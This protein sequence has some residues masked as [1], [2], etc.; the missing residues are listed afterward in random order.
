M[1]GASRPKHWLASLAK[2]FG[3]R[4]PT[5]RE[6]ENAWG[7][8]PQFKCGLRPQM[9][10]ASLVRVKCI[11]AVRAVGTPPPLG[12]GCRLGRHLAFIPPPQMHSANTIQ[13]IQNRLMDR[14]RKKQRP[15][16]SV[17][18]VSLGLTGQSMSPRLLAGCAPLPASTREGTL[19]LQIGGASLFSFDCWLRDSCSP[20]SGGVQPALATPHRTKFNRN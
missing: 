4:P 19:G 20:R 9:W 3:L 1:R 6:K 11:K 7:F 17:S 16:T 14:R 5:K 13:K 10:L 2:R 18:W 12:V 15:E 8:A